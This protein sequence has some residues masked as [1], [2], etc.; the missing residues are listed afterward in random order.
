VDVNGT[1]F[2]LVIG[3]TGWLG[4]DPPDQ[5]AEP[6][7]GL[8]WHSADHTLRLAEL[9]FVFPERSGNRRLG[10][11]DRRG[12]ARDRY[13]NW[14][15]IG[16]GHDE[17]RLQTPGTAGSTRFWPR[18]QPCLAAEP[19]TGD[20]TPAGSAAPGVQRLAGLAVT[21]DHHLAVGVP[22]VPGLLVFDLHAGGP[23]TTLTW[24]AALRPVDMAAAPG[25]GLWIL[26]G[27]GGPGPARYWGLDRLW[28]IRDLAGPG[29]AP[30]PP[31]DFAPLPTGSV[32][33]PGDP[34]DRGPGSGN[35]ERGSPVEVATGWAVAIEAL[36]DGSVL[37]LDRGAPHPAQVLRM[38]G[39]RELGRI[40][41]APIVEPVDLAFLGDAGGAAGTVFVAESQ[42]DQAFALALA[43][44][45]STLTPET[46]YLPMRLFSGK[47]LVASRGQ[48]YYDLGERWLPVAD[49]RSPRYVGA[50]SLVTG[51]FDAGEPG[52]VWH[53]LAIDGRF[54][55]GTGVA[56]QSRTADESEAL[57][58]TAWREEPAPYLRAAGSEVPYHRF[59][60][61]GASDAGTV[62]VLL[63][64]ARGRYLQ[65]RLQL[66][67]DGRHTPR[68]WGLRVHRPRFSYLQHYL[69]DFY[70]DDPEAADF[71]DRYLANTEGLLTEH[72]GRI[73][74]AQRLLDVTSLD[75]EHIAWLGG[76]LGVTTDPA[77]DE[78]R[79]RLLVQHAVEL[80]GR[81][82]TVRGLV[83][84]VR[85]ATDP[86]PDSTIFDGTPVPGFGVRVI[87]AF[88]TRAVPPPGASGGVGA[89]ASGPRVVG[90]G[91]RWRVDEGRGELDRRYRE[92]VVARHPDVAALKAAWGR[93]VATVDGE[94]TEPFPPLTPGSRR[95]A[96]D[97]RDF[98]VAS[99]AVPY[100]DV[101]AR[102]AT[103][104]RVFLAQQYRE[105]AAL[106]AAWGLIGGSQLRSF[107]EVALPGAAVPSDGP[108]LQDWFSFASSYLPAVRTAHRFTVLVPM[109]LESSDAAR[110][111]RLAQV[112]RVVEQ[113]RPA[114]TGY[115]VRP[116]WAAFR[117]GDARVGLETSLA[118]GSRF[119]ALVL[120]EGRTAQ[121]RLGGGH[122]WDVPDRWVV[123]RD[124][125]LPRTGST[126]T[127][128]GHG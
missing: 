10:P 64:R 32:A 36:P 68:L 1:G 102:D 18:S 35:G 30:P 63:Q 31:E 15:W 69:P 128:A 113:E 46:R 55:S 109:S 124:R 34:A 123:G 7:E 89:V 67:G 111:D 114:H 92:F 44:D 80:F 51:P 50:A 100:A 122:P 48:V 59:G 61:R 43:A 28:R 38:R 14:F 4:G 112:T 8:A 101:S 52:T 22:D 29:E 83:E 88:R 87:E 17:V 24:P 93:S 3:R 106:S 105:P 13:G 73:A 53:R 75:A 9:P 26:D 81:R 118:Q 108:A 5:V 104:Y 62:E 99:L 40:P 77:W 47:A 39:A 84:A 103:S 12:A 79:S 127:E 54:P 20:F 85:L 95:E 66:S 117:V 65:V 25:G 41:L 110:A 11:A 74:A 42:G 120:G 45:G 107:D 97:R 58:L 19:P 115:E 60:A 76:W 116:F 86:C 56:V 126:R 27:T 23:P 125:V 78:A 91:A 70:R 2:V 57:E 119:V 37:V 94:L 96:T 16:A 90:L 82:G 71:L 21:D 72:E 49:R 121:G 6:P 33:D 98:V